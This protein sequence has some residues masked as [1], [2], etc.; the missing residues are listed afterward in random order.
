MH[1]RGLDDL[2]YNFPF[3]QAILVAYPFL[4]RVHKLLLELQSSNSIDFCLAS[5]SDSWLFD[6]EGF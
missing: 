3:D 6:V 1:P 4:L 2:F 5:S